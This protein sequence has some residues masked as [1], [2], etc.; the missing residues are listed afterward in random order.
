[1]HEHETSDAST[2][3]KS[4]VDA[5]ERQLIQSALAAAAGNQRRAAAALGLLPT[6]LHEKMKRLG[7]LRRPVPRPAELAS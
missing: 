1:M 4:M 5:Y 6:T 3:L 7:L 2:S